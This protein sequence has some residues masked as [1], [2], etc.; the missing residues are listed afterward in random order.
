MIEDNY[1][2]TH[3]QLPPTT[4]EERFSWLRLLRSRRVGI[5]T[6]N[7]LMVE[8]G[9]AAAALEALPEIARRRCKAIRSLPRVGYSPRT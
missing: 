9:S 4:E 5:S 7:R 2:S 8:H 6:F 1:S 3:P